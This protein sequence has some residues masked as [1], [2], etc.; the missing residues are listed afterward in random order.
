MHRA[1]DISEL[2]RQ[3]DYI[4]LHVP[5]IK[6]KTHHLL[7]AEA[8]R[9]MKPN[10]CICNFA[11]GEI[12]DGAA[13][14]V[15]FESGQKTGKYV[16]DFAD[17]DLMGHSQHIVMPH[18]GA[19]T[20]EAEENS[21]AMAAE[22]IMDFLETGSIKNSVNFPD[23]RLEPK[24]KHSSRLCI[25]NENHPGVLGAITTFLGEEGI[26]IEQQINLSRGDLA[27]T[28]IDMEGLP[29]APEDL[30][31]RLGKLE[32]ILSSRFIGVPFHNEIGRPGTFYHVTWFAEN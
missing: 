12:V 2:Y 23:A 10:V 4:S 32:G 9:Q 14:R 18:L 5:Y 1:K 26:N 11:R 15:A 27:Y 22:Q 19:S 3:A 30:Q 7:D 16:S 24:D 29:S 6:D 28:V 25:V 21:A 20:A 31:N 13:L 8:I 17:A